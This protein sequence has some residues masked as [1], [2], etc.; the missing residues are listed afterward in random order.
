VAT[1]SRFT[2]RPDDARTFPEWIRHRTRL[3][4]DKVAL[5]VCGATR[6]YAELDDRT[7]RT[8]AGFASLGLRQ[9]D[10]VSLMMQNSIENIEAWFGLQKAGIVEVP[11]HTASRGAALQ[12]IVDHADART[13]VVDEVFLPHVAAI[14]GELAQVRQVIVNRNEPGEEAVELP[15]RIAVHDL[16]E[17]YDTGA[18]VPTPRVERAH[19]AVVLHSSGT[20]GPPKGVVLSHDAVLHL[21]RHLVWLMGYGSDDRLYTA[22]PL[23]HNNAKYTTVTA[24]LEAGASCVLDKRF[25]VKTFWEVAREKEISAFNYMGALV[26]ML[27]KQPY[28]PADGDNPVR[29]AFGAPC[30]VEIWED[31]ERRFGVQLVEVYGMT[32]APMGCENRLDNRKIGSAGRESMTYEMRIVDENDEPVPPN[33]PGEIVLRPKVA[34]AIFSGYYRREA[35]TVEAWR[36]LWFHT[37]DRGTMDEDGF[38]FF[39]DRMKDCIRRRGEN[40]STWEVESAVNT[41]EAVLES[42]AYG[43]ASELSESEVM[44]A[45]VLQPGASLEPVE[46]LDYCHGRMA[47]FAIP[48]YVRFVDALPKNASE[49]VEKFK[50][51]EEAVT[52][53]TWDREAHGYTVR[54]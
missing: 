17:L 32:E 16:A 11:V 12:Y 24:A 43:V 38:L 6:T 46:L 22:F 33:T 29:I 3:G 5:E 47:H 21:T 18:P 42:A 15:S 27:H 4:G 52:G 35:D 14:V 10:H 39:L 50:L 9:G 41:H 20:T 53:T 26:M 1:G 51:R 54:R 23:F 31:F 40:I 34:G 25:P 28:G 37:G 30:P 7:D 2:L 49:R 19:T 44:I 45:V 13:L 8:A 48:R 36:N